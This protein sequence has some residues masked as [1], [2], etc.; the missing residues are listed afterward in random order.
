MQYVRVST[1]YRALKLLG[2]V[3]CDS[4]RVMRPYSLPKTTPNR[5]IDAI[6][7]TRGHRTRA[8]PGRRAAKNCEFVTILAVCW[9]KHVFAASGSSLGFPGPYVLL[10]G[11]L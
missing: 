7:R 2:R 11:L 6:D 3:L 10:S 1:R 4:C 9:H 8:V 5:G